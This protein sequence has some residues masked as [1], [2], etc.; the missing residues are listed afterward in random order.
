ML[1]SAYI[2]TNF[3]LIFVNHCPEDK[4]NKLLRNVGNQL[5]L[6]TASY[7][8]RL[9]SSSTILGKTQIVQFMFALCMY[10]RHLTRELRHR[11][12]K[13]TREEQADMQ[14]EKI[15]KEKKRTVK[16]KKANN[17]FV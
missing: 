6:G 2:Y 8:T 17:I 15:Y 13:N 4:L 3:I 1:C 9:H 5:S 7:P 14:H 16:T 11:A 10:T 12:I